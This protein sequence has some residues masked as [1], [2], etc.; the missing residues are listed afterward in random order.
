VYTNKGFNLTMT[1]RT[2]LGFT[3]SELLVSLSVLGLI[4]ALTLPSIFNSVSAGKIKANQKEAIQAVQQ[5]LYQGYMNGDF[6]SIT[7]W[8]FDSPNDPS[9]QYVTS[10]LNAKNCPMGITTG[11]CTHN[12]N[13]YG[14]GNGANNH[15]GR[16][17]LPTGTLIWLHN[18]GSVVNNSTRMNFLIDGDPN[19]TSKLDQAGAD[20]LQVICNISDVNRSYPPD[21][22]VVQPGQCVP[23]S[24]HR[25]TYEALYRN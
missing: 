25:I 22:T 19:G 1:K 18:N 15:S 24:N 7:D 23:F 21:V 2:R 20:Q 13:N 6:A 4:A 5:M 11:G 3:L 8:S 9:I 12:W 17:V 10:K 14:Y 16:W